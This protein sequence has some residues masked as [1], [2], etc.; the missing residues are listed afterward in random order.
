MLRDACACQHLLPWV[1]QWVVNRQRGK[2]VAAYKAFTSCT[3]PSRF[4]K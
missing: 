4:K 2:R 1:G 3:P